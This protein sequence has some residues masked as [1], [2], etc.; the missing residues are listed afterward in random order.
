MQIRDFALCVSQENNTF[1]RKKEKVMETPKNFGA[2]LTLVVKHLFEGASVANIKNDYF[3]DVEVNPEGTSFNHAP[4][5]FACI[6]ILILNMQYYLTCL[7]FQK[8]CYL[9]LQ[10]KI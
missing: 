3:A 7:R 6:T 8:E 2:L 4:L 5:W 9:K 10:L 1:E